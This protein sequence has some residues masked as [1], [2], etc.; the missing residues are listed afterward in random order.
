MS[1]LFTKIYTFVHF[2]N[3]GY[4]LMLGVLDF[5]F[6]RLNNLIKRPKVQTETITKAQTGR[7]K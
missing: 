2:Y 4:Y 5:F 1:F 7:A 6:F 3:I